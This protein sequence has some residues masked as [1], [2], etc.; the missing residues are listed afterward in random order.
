VSCV[1]FIVASCILGDATHY[2]GKID[3]SQPKLGFEGVPELERFGSYSDPSQFLFTFCC[4][5]SILITS[6]AV[7]FSVIVTAVSLTVLS[8]KCHVMQ[9]RNHLQRC[10][11]RCSLPPGK[12]ICVKILDD[13]LSTHL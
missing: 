5:V 4:Q 8:D 9:L 12:F 1:S 13:L 2:L 10:L 3:Y 6:Q 7:R 11:A